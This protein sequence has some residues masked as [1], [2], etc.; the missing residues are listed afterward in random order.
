METRI[1]A[2]E[3]FGMPETNRP[4]ELV[5]G[6]VKEPPAPLYGHQKAVGQL[7]YLLKMHVEQHHLGE[8]CVSPIDVVL[9]EAAALVVQ[10]DVIFVSNERSSIIRN[11]I[12][13]APDVVVEVVSP[14]T[15]QRDRTVKLAWYRRYGVR[16]C[17]IV[18]PHTRTIDVVNCAGGTT[19]SFT[20]SQAIR[21]RAVPGFTSSADDCLP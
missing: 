18:T 6:V 17:W 19:E 8:V 1:T 2:N 13:G 15:E 5:Y 7:F 16:E 20:G 9:D 14:G 11:Y 10:P 4:A 21:S 3:Y 12:V